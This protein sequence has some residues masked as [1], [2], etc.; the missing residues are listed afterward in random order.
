MCGNGP[1]YCKCL[2]DCTDYSNIINPEL[3]KWNET[4][5]PLDNYTSLST[6]DFLQERYSSITFI[7]D[8]LVRNIFQAFMIHVTDDA[9]YGSMHYNL[10][11]EQLSPCKNEMQYSETGCRLKLSTQI[12]RCN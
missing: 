8:S 5:C 10:T 7:G 6:C 2:P 3:M 9:A 4:F 11:R 12:A 1:E